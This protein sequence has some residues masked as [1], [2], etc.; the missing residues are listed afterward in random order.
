MKKLIALVLFAAMMFAFVPTASALYN[1]G[2]IV[3][4]LNDGAAPWYGAQKP[5]T[6]SGTKDTIGYNEGITVEIKDDPATIAA[7]TEVNKNKT[8][9]I[10]LTGSYK[11]AEAHWYSNNTQVPNMNVWGKAV[12][13]PYDVYSVDDAG[14]PREN[15]TNIASLDGMVNYNWIWSGNNQGQGA[16][17]NYYYLDFVLSE[18]DRNQEYIVRYSNNGGYVIIKIVWDNTDNNVSKVGGPYPSLKVVGYDNSTA[19]YG[20]Y[21]AEFKDMKWDA[22]KKEDVKGRLTFNIAAYTM[23]DRT[24]IWKAATTMRKF[25]RNFIETDGGT[26]FDSLAIEMFIEG[27]ENFVPGGEVTGATMDLAIQKVVKGTVNYTDAGVNYY[28]YSLAAPTQYVYLSDCKD[29]NDMVVKAGWDRRS[30][31]DRF[32]AAAPQYAAYT[33]V[34]DVLR[35]NAQSYMWHPNDNRMDVRLK[36]FDTKGVAYPAGTIIAIRDLQ[37]NYQRNSSILQ[38]TTDYLGWGGSNFTVYNWDRY[39]GKSSKYVNIAYEPTY[40]IDQNNCFVFSMFGIMDFA[41]AAGYF[42]DF[43]GDV[44]DLTALGHY[45]AYTDEDI[46]LL[47]QNQIKLIQLLFTNGKVMEDIKFDVY[48]KNINRTKSSITIL[49]DREININLGAEVSLPYVLDDALAMSTEMQDDGW[50]TSEKKIVEVTDAKKGTIKAKAI[51]KAY[52]YAKDAAGNF[53]LFIVNVVDPSQVAPQPPVAEGKTYVVTA[54]K[55]NVRTGP[56]TN[57]K[58]LGTISRNTEV[59]GIE[60]EGSVWV[61]ITAEVGGKTVTAYVSG[62]YLAEK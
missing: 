32:A 41:V 26:K 11:D 43:H 9:E 40:V 34:Y 60:I 3:N 45:G 57:N 24:T 31:F 8:I 62:K 36:A 10:K 52:I 53:Q 39:L 58:S 61:Q 28:H 13:I 12:K 22:D 35:I 21:T 1:E 17:Q 49:G 47:Y 46:V 42:K 18:E 51:G 15:V 25:D 19:Q 2:F 33:V 5:E 54:S 48:Y 59:Q 14:Q 4:I 6:V 30:E 23:A 27:V 38:Y 56:G 29:F 44:N 16:A 55:L 20:N 7:G 50:T 37:L